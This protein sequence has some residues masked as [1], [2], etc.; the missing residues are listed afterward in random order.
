MPVE[1]SPKKTVVETNKDQKKTLQPGETDTHENQSELDYDN[2]SPLL[3]NSNLNKEQRPEMNKQFTSPLTGKPTVL[4][5]SEKLILSKLMKEEDE[6][7]ALKLYQK[8]S[9]RF[10][11][12]LE[13]QKPINL[14]KQS[15]NKSS[16]ETNLFDEEPIIQSTAHHESQGKYFPKIVPKMNNGEPKIGYTRPYNDLC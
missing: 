11:Q 13:N 2:D 9:K 15:S 6:E 12:D 7:N 10:S 3:C 14:S 8:L 16:S 5:I 4:N 1:H